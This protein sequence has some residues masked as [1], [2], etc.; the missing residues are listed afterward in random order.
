M[1]STTSSIGVSSGTCSTGNAACDWTDYGF[2]WSDGANTTTPTVG[3]TNCNKVKVGESGTGTSWTGSITPSGSTTPTSWTTGHTYY[4]RTYGKN[5]KAG[6]EFAYG[7]AWSFTPRSITFN[8]NGHGSSTP[9]T[10]YVNSGSKVSDPSYSESVSGWVFGGW[11]REAE[12]TNEWTFGTDV[13]S[14]DTTLYAKWTQK[15][16]TPTF[17]PAAG[18][19]TGTQSVTIS[20]A[21][22]SNAT[23]RYTTDGTTPTKSVGTV[24]SEAISVSATTTI[25]A[26]AYKD[27]CLDSEVAEGTFTIKC[28]TPTFSVA[29][30][31]KHGAQS[32][33]LSCAT[34]DATIYYTT[35]N[36]T[37]TASSTE[38]TGTAIDV[39][40]SQT[41][42]AIAIKS[43]LSNSEVASAAYTI[44][45]QVTWTV[46][47]ADN[48]I[49]PTWV[50]C[51]S[52]PTLPDAPDACDATSTTFIGWTQTRW[53]DKIAQSAIDAK[54]TDATK[55]HTSNSTMPNVSTNVTYHA[56]WAK[57]SST[58]SNEW[59]LVTSESQ[60]SAGD[61]I[62][63]ATG[64]S[65]TV[66]LVGYQNITYEEDGVTPK[67]QN[68]KNASNTATVSLSKITLAAANIASTIGDT[69]KPYA[70]TLGKNG[71]YWT[72]YDPIYEGYLY[73]SSPA[74]VA[75]TGEKNWVYTRASDSD[76]A[77][78]WS[79][80]VSGT[81]TITSQRT[82]S[83]RILLMFN[84]GIL[85][86]YVDVSS[87]RTEAYIFRNLSTTSYSDYMT[88]C[89]DYHVTVNDPSIT[90]AA[91]SGS[92][93]TFD[94][95]HP[96]TCNGGATV[97]ATLT[98]AA[99]YQ[100]SA[101]SFTRSDDDDVSVSPAISTPI[102]STTVYTLTFGNEDN[103][104]LSTS[105]T[106]QAKPVSSWTW[107]YGGEAIPNPVNL[108]V[109]EKAR[110]DV[111]YTPSDVILSKKTYTRTKVDAYINWYGGDLQPTYF[112]CSGR[113]S[114]GDNTTPVTVTHADGPET[115]IYVK[116]KALPTVTFVDLIHNKM[117]FTNS[118]E[119]WTAGTGV[120]SSTV[121]T[122]VVSHAKKT[123]TH[124]DVSAPVGGNT[125]ET[126][127]LHLIGWIR[128][129]WP[130]LVAY[131]NGTGS[132]SDVE[133]EDITGAGADGDS[134]NYFFSP[135]ADINVETYNGKTFY[136]VWAVE[137]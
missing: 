119:G 94:K 27:G 118:G 124:T 71:D 38:Y 31:T 98:L 112:Y 26:I 9:D 90:D 64:S 91:S 37:P 14:K 57:G 5:S 32:V 88:T 100:A 56:V 104:T 113:A 130:A 77:S 11:F 92:T 111:E 110:F 81:A 85:S 12:C 52:K 43:G 10:K 97:Q 66:S 24:Y 76:A 135:D 46:N 68:R 20:C 74:T 125:C 47:G 65:S 84:S 53:D 48:T 99:G 35:N 134:K 49:T 58:P 19:H 61:K 117:D 106:I 120:L 72:I 3:G 16:S 13:V 123:P 80:S 17:S 131:M 101:L 128:S 18:T 93:I 4:V 2:V 8:L 82:T 7:N 108:Y 42:K 45:Y 34:A 30:G 39:S 73:A 36:S 95:T 70:F 116:V 23:I 78:R 29:A 132:A 15:C 127:H 103:I 40:T 28:A 115:T 59:G 60:L 63:L 133:T 86:C 33:E 54:T 21:A 22:P 114:T 136:A 55:V 122:G 126:E 41:I 121:S 1:T 79:I 44:Q 75:G 102:T 50:N 25:K 137:E 69:E 105:A 51:G 83:N 107:T 87:G 89:C 67:S 96:A 129:D 62:V 109:G 6:A